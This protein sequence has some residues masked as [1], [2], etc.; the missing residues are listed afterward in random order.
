MQTRLSFAVILIKV[1]D[2]LAEHTENSKELVAWLNNM[3][4][5]NVL[6]SIDPEMVELVLGAIQNFWQES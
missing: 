1:R 2:E 6:L 4:W 5:E 3:L